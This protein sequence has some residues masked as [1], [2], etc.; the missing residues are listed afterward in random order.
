LIFTADEAVA[1][2]A[3]LA[4]S[5]ASGSAG[6]SELALTALAKIEQ[7]LPSSARRRVRALRSSVPLG[8]GTGFAPGAY[9]A[10]LDVSILGVL[11]LA[12]RDSERVRLRY[13]NT[14]GAEA[15]TD[16][17]RRVEPAALVPRGTRW[18]LI[19]RDLDRGWRALRVDRITRVEPTGVRFS[20]CAVPGG[21][22]AAFLATELGA[23]PRQYAATILIHAPID[24]VQAYMGGFATDFS[25]TILESGEPGTRWHVAD[26]RLEVLAGG[27]LWVRWPFDVV[28]SPELAELL[29]DRAA[30]F[31]A[32]AGS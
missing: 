5:A 14:A 9:P 19:G 3:A 2:A 17:A 8:S 24:Q 20:A 12:C 29:R 13:M 30:A 4:S 7:V 16:P 32:A 23:P 11:A 21:D 28:D 6:G 22:P 31:A 27:L 1:I 26:V 15:G 10:P 18:Y 25:P